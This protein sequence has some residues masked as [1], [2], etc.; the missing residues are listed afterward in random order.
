[1]QFTRFRVMLRIAITLIIMMAISI[2]S[3][4]AQEPPKK[5]PYIIYGFIFDKNGKLVHFANVTVVET[6]SRQMRS[7]IADMEGKYKIA[8]DDYKIGDTIKIIASDG[9]RSGINTTVLREG[10]A[11]QVDV[12]ISETLLPSFSLIEVVISISFLFILNKRV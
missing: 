8:I 1:M 4:Q 12:T 3:T 9:N 6:Q 2:M 10:T 7:G 5:D 11:M